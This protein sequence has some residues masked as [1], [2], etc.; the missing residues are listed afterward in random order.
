MCGAETETLTHF[1]QECLALQDLRNR[2]IE[3]SS[4]SVTK[5]LLFEEH[6]VE[7]PRR[8][9]KYLARLWMKRK[10]LVENLST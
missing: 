8:H 7:D 1:L 9:M 10:E 4:K 2:S 6:N 5:L 3:I